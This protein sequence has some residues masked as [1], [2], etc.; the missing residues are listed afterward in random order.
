MAC[1]VL[2]RESVKINC[3]DVVVGYKLTLRLIT[4]DVR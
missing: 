2:K 1:N 3:K 4:E